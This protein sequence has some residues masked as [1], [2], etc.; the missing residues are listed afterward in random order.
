MK[1][2]L[3]SI[4]LSPFFILNNAR[5][6]EKYSLEDL[7]ALFKQ[8]S[9][10]EMLNHMN[11]ISPKKRDKK[12][13]SLLTK[14]SI[15]YANLNSSENECGQAFGYLSEQVKTYPFL[16]KENSFLDAYTKH[17]ICAL[18]NDR[19]YRYEWQKTGDNITKIDPRGSTLYKLS[20]ETNYSK[21]FYQHI[22]KN[23]NKYKKDKLVANFIH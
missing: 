21:G 1:L 22:L 5:S 18:K 9:F 13:K 10:Q 12:W 15:A 4:L 20:T 11:D 14:G 16:K 2:L 6:S 8:E 17:G 7:D 3:F 23:K 19:Y